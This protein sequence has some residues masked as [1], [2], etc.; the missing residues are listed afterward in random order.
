MKLNDYS[1]NKMEPSFL[2]NQLSREIADHSLEAVKNFDHWS[3]KNNLLT[4]LKLLA[5]AAIH[6]D[7]VKKI[8]PKGLVEVCMKKTRNQKSMVVG[9]SWIWE[10]Q[11][12]LTA[13]GIWLCDEGAK[14]I[15]NSTM[16]P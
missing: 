4:G 10:Q 12:N 3:A 8:N 14:R 9:R 6:E 13:K 11:W 15:P 5:A 2:K 16:A 1:G 7:Q